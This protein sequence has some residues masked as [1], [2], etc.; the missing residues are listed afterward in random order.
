MKEERERIAEDA[1]A[2]VQAVVV[3]GIVPGGGAIEIAASREVSAL[4]DGVRGMASYGV[5]ASPRP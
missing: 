2:S 4:R 5:D 1:A 3:G